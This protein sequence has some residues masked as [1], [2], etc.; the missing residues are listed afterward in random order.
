M[1][2]C[3]CGT[4][5]TQDEMQSTACVCNNCRN[6]KYLMTPKPGTFGNYGWICPR[7]GKVHSPYSTVCDCSPVVGVLN[8]PTNAGNY[9]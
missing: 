9:R 1:K 3:Q 4:E 5:L 7:C 6:G 8:V 2:C